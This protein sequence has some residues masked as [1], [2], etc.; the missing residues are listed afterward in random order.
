M[1][2]GLG[3]RLA[4]FGTTELE[5]IITRHGIKGTV[6]DLLSYCFLFI[7]FGMFEVE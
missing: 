4:V 1:Q 2:V 5:E 3:R 6:T 7:Y